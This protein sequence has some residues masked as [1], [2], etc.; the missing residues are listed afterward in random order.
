MQEVRK[1]LMGHAS[2]EDVNSIYTHIE[3]PVK[4]DAI[5][6][7]E[8]WRETQLEAQRQLVG[9]PGSNGSEASSN[10]ER[11]EGDVKPIEARDHA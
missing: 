10:H 5:R 4:R 8:A 11:R 2:G 9:S 7:L 1:A 3:L 6:K